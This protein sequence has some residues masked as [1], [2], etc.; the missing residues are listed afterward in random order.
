[1]MYRILQIP[2]PAITICPQITS[3]KFTEL[4]YNLKVKNVSLYDLDENG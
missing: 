3:E 4:Y 1:M 2:F